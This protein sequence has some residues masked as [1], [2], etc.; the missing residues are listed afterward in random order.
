MSSKELDRIR[1]NRYQE[2]LIYSSASMKHLS[3]H[4]ETQHLR[5]EK[6]MI[7]LPLSRTAQEIK[8]YQWRVK[9]EFPIVK[10]TQFSI[11][12]SNT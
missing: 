3:F 12:H 9:T 6:T 4:R 2:K 5:L 1:F 11:K 7:S 8:T 10:V